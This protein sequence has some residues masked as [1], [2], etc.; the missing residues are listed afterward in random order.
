MCLALYFYLYKQ[1]KKQWLPLY[2]RYGPVSG[3]GTPFQTHLIKKLSI[4]SQTIV[5]FLEGISIKS[6]SFDKLDV[7]FEF[8][9]HK[10]LC[11]VA[12]S[13][14]NMKMHF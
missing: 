8:S 10:L 6:R 9:L 5:V 1:L 12:N 2:Y 11:N 14:K 13:G 3:T 4:N 7:A